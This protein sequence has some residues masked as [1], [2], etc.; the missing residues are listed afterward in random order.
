[1]YDIFCIVDSNFECVEYELMSV[2]VI[3]IEEKLIEFKMRCWSKKFVLPKSLT[4]YELANVTRYLLLFT[5]F[6]FQLF[7]NKYLTCCHLHIL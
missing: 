5:T 7:N 3:E 6:I 4:H 1:M 2:K